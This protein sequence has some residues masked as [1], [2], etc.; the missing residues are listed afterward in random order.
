M[1]F[2]F[3]IVVAGL[4]GAMGVLIGAMGAHLF[5][6]N[7]SGERA[8]FFEKAWRYHMLHVIA[9]LA[10]SWMIWIFEYR[11][12]GV[13]SWSARLAATC[14]AFGI[15]L[16]SGVLYLQAIAGGSPTVPLVPMGGMSFVFGWIMI[17]VSGFRLPRFDKSDG[18]KASHL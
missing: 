10:C 11:F 13:G 8:V 18:D 2:R 12:E 14:F 6:D 3:W 1:G 15:L 16:F 5:T 7:L 17:A 9:I 4:L